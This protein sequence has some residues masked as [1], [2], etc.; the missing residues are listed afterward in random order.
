MVFIM[1]EKDKHYISPLLEIRPLLPLII[2]ILMATAGVVIY[3]SRKPK[4]E[5]PKPKTNNLGFRL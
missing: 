2:F 1:L 3:L 5:S 4:A